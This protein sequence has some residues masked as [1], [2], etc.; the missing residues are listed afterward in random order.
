METF[1]LPV[2]YGKD[3]QNRKKQWHIIVEKSGEVAFIKTVYGCVNGKLVE[4]V[5]EVKQGKNVG[6]KNSTSVFEQACLEAKSKWKKKVENEGFRDIDSEET[7][8]LQCVSPMLAHDYK[9]QGHK[10]S[11]PCFVQ[12]KLDGYRAIWKNGKFFS[13]QGNQFEV[14]SPFFQHI[15]EVQHVLDGELYSNELKF[16]EL[17]VLR[18]KNPTNKDLDVLNKIEYHVYD[19][20]DESLTFENRVA[21]LDS[22]KAKYDKLIVVD[23]R[24][25]R[26]KDDLVSI[27]AQNIQNGYE[28]TMIRNKRGLYMQKYRSCDLQKYKDFQDD[29]FEIIGYEREQG[30]LIVWVCQTHNGKPFNVQSKGSRE[31]RKKLYQTGKQHIG[32]KLWVKF[33]EYTADGIP[34]FP[35]TMRDGAESIRNVTV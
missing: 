14:I 6:K 32:K 19:I 31:Q 23:T 2:L 10:I 20:V 27:H 33:F 21:L 4:S 28:G 9:K 29:E 12:P 17:G 35:K 5:R 26:G 7:E 30:D 8:S 18:K 15:S 13:R 16:E 24:D 25:C 34:R 1:S 11:F 22:L 3:K